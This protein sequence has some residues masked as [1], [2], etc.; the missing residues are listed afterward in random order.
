[1][2]ESI[3]LQSKWCDIKTSDNQWRLA[4][5]LKIDNDLLTVSFDG[6][7]QNKNKVFLKFI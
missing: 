5:I 7:S 3:I 6:W 4:S 1:M 2:F